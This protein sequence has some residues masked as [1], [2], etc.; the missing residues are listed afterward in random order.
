MTI[1]GGI[2]LVLAVIVLWPRGGTTN[3]TDKIIYAWSPVSI[4][5]WTITDTL[6][7]DGSTQFVRS[8]KLTFWQA[9][10]RVTNVFV[11]LWDQ[12]QADQVLAT[13]DGA[14]PG[15]DLK[16]AQSAVALAQASYNNALALED[17]ESALRDAQITLDKARLSVRDIDTTIDIVNTNEDNA[18]AKA[19]QTLKDAQKRYDDL[20]C[21]DCSSADDD[22]RTRRT[23]Y[24]Q[25]VEYLRQSRHS[26][27]NNLDSLDKIM[28]YTDKFQLPGQEPSQYIW[29]ND[30]S[31]LSETSKAFFQVKRWLDKL[32]ESYTSLKVIDVDDLSF[33]EFDNAYALLNDISSDLI[34]LWNRARNMFDETLVGRA[35]ASAGPPMQQSQVDN[36][37][38]LAEGIYD[39]WSHIRQQAAQTLD[40]IHALDDATSEDS[41][42]KARTILQDAQLALDQLKLSKSQRSA[43]NASMRS[44]AERVLAQT[45]KQLELVRNGTYDLSIQQAKNNLIQA[46]SQL[47]SL[48]KR[49]EDYELI[50]NFAGVVSDMDIKIGDKSTMSREPYIVVENTNLIEIEVEADQVDILKINR[51][52]KVNIWIDALEQSFSGSINSVSTV[53]T[54]TNN[55]ASYSFKAIFEKPEDITILAW[56]S[57]TLTLTTATKHDALRVPNSALVHQHNATFVNRI[58]GSLQEVEIWSSDG[59]WT[60]ILSGLQVWDRIMSIV[61]TAANLEHSGVAGSYSTD[62]S[63]P[64]DIIGDE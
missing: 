62:F 8:Q 2:I 44:D 52:D 20:T 56:L 37:L 51:G 61:I 17:P 53:P 30:R 50:A 39:N 49:Y 13:I 48:R 60:E 28:Y 55:T 27:Q 54:M 23:T 63:W 10:L 9:W 29:A 31:T 33:R 41:I 32:D 24:S 19:E 22:T 25:A 42:N 40:R 4:D 12:V 47:T 1:L 59:H 64:R 38:N 16:A 15:A 26:I 21:E 57:A 45:Q 43:N 35:M 34:E 18:I 46:Q 36:Y 5:R 58:D 14:S 11:E 7:F 6:S 3:N